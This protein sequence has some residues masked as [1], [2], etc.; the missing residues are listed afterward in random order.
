MNNLTWAIWQKYLVKRQVKFRQITWKIKSTSFLT[1][2]EK[3][4]VQIKKAPNLQK[5]D[6]A[7]GYG[8]LSFLGV[9]L[10]FFFL[11]HRKSHKTSFVPRT[12]LVCVSLSILTLTLVRILCRPINRLKC[13]SNW[14]TDQHGLLCPLHQAFEVNLSKST[15]IMLHVHWTT[16]D[17]VIQTSM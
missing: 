4:Q 13:F 11:W 16:S 10:V 7:Y 8:T 9:F 1:N 2:S 14:F 15:T 6:C 5:V 3:Q 17:H 12:L